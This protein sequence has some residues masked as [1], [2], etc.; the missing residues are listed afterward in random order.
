MIRGQMNLKHLADALDAWKN[1]VL[2]HVTAGEPI[3]VVPMFT[4]AG[5][6]SDAHQH[7]YA[8]LL[9]TDT[10]RIVNATIDFTDAGRTAYFR[11]ASEQLGNA[12]I[13]FVDPDNGPWTGKARM[14]PAHYVKAS[15]LATLLPATGPRVVLAYRHESRNQ[16]LQGLQSY[17]AGLF[18]GQA[19][20]AA[21]ALLCGVTTLICASRDRA[22][23]M[24]LREKLIA[25]LHPIGPYRVTD[26]IPV[27]QH[28]PPY[29]P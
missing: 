29:S 22:Q 25:L 15:E 2:A 23:V 21:F 3:W 19:G 1:W 24:A 28:V 7:L 14:T 4:D 16:T 18:Q 9:R 26:V 11:Q 12:A 27:V 6:W 5:A 8:S 10:S 13:V 20:V 17:V